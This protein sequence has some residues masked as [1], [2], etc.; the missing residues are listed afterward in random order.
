MVCRSQSCCCCEGLG[1][2]ACSNSSSFCLTFGSSFGF[3]FR[4]GLGFGRPSG[5]GP[6]SPRVSKV[7]R[8]RVC[9][10]GGSLTSARFRLWFRVCCLFRLG[11]ACGGLRKGP[12]LFG[13][14]PG[15][16]SS[17]PTRFSFSCEPGWLPHSFRAKTFVRINWPGL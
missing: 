14:G 3:C 7:S 1:Q 16:H 8:H 4:L 11:S 6:S 9:R 2:R 15:S 12:V 10:R 13:L 17:E 5:K